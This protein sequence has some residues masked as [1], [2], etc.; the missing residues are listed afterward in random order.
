MV[1]NSTIVRSVRVA[2]AVV[3]WVSPPLASVW[4]ERLFLT[5]RNAPAPDRERDWVAGAQQRV[6]ELPGGARIPLW[7]WGS[8]GP[9]V[10][11]VH[12]WAGRG[13]QLAALVEPLRARG[14]RVATYD[15]PAHGGAVGARQT[16]LPDM[17]HAVAAVAEEVGEVQVVVAHSLGTAA[18]VR[19]VGDGLPVARLVFVA[20]PANPGGYLGQL[21]RYLGFG[22]AVVARTQRRIQLRVGRTFDDLHTE[23][24]A[25][26]MSRPLLVVHDRG[27]RVVPVGEGEAVAAAWPGAALLITKGLGHQRI[28]RDPNVV[29]EVAGFVGGEP[30]A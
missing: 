27:D 18:A 24:L 7:I 4:L 29:R 19:A 30:P 5:P 21:G 28:L 3:S 13:P 26:T 10:L 17:A 6:L 9:T 2:A 23:R 14:W 25:G 16:T 8:S 22:D 15:A 12:G 1:M 11:L 20:P